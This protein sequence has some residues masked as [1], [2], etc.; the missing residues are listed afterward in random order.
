MNSY[1]LIVMDL[2]HTLPNIHYFIQSVLTTSVTSGPTSLSVLSISSYAQGKDY[3]EGKHRVQPS[4]SIDLTSTFT[5]MKSTSLINNHK[6]SD[7]NSSSSDSNNSKNNNKDHKHN[8][9]NGQIEDSEEH[10][11]NHLTLQPTIYI[12]VGPTPS[13]TVSTQSISRSPK[14]GVSAD[15]YSYTGVHL[16]SPIIS[17]PA[18]LD[19]VTTSSCQKPTKS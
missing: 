17:V 7:N 9:E 19:T 13:P 14:L 15:S 1:G 18:Y 3:F 4:R 8:D 12:P 6:K 16:S 11:E 5:K 2:R 10:S